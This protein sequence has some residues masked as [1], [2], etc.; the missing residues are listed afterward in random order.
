MARVSVFRENP[1]RRAKVQTTR[2]NRHIGPQ[3]GN[4]A[5][6][7]ARGPLIISHPAPYVN[8]QNKRI[9]GQIFGKIAQNWQIA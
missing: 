1:G 2:K 9:I 6:A 3:T 4:R 5:L 8:I 7:N